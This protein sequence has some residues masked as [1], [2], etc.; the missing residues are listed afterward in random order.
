MYN[1][2][3]TRPITSLRDRFFSHVDMTGDCWQWTGS[4][5]TG[6]YGTI[7]AEAPSR[8]KLLRAHRVAYELMVGPIPEGLDL[9][10]LC[11]NRGCVRPSH[12]EPVTRR[13]NLSRGLG[14]ALKTHC[15]QGHEYTE[16][17]TYRRPGG[18][19]DCRTCRYE[20]TTAHYARVRTPRVPKTHC[21]HGHEFTPENTYK[22][23][24]GRACRTC[25]RERARANYHANKAV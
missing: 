21:P 7:V 4:L 3:M 18:T 19:R 9:D 13:E 17:N 5:A 25:A 6:G 2:V 24:H 14:G 16:E 11:R 10:H 1:T 15:A 20:S 22:T 12:L 8:G 23:K